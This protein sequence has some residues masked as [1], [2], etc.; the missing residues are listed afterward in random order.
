MAVDDVE[1][2]R[3]QQQLSAAE[4]KQHAVCVTRDVASPDTTP[5]MIIVFVAA[6]FLMKNTVLWPQK[7]TLL[8]LIHYTIN[9]WPLL[10]Y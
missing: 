5:P 2:Q 8:T 3:L 6:T 1:P 4:P 9:P 7:Q 10:H